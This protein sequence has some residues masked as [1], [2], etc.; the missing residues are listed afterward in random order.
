[1]SQTES[2]SAQFPISRRN[3]LGS[4]AVIGAGA[5]LSQCGEAA[6]AASFT[7]GVASGDPLPTAVILWTR[8]VPAGGAD[9]ALINWEISETEAFSSVLRSGYTIADGSLDFTVKVD[10]DGLSPG[11][12]YFYRFR[13]GRTSSP[14]GRTRTLPAGDPEH[15]TIAL[16]SCSNYAFGYFNAYADCARRDDIDV[17]VHVGDYIYEYGSG[18][19]GDA[20]M[21]AADR[22]LVPA[23]DLVTLADYRARYGL[24][25]S[26]PDLQEMHRRHPMIAVWDDHEV[27]NDAWMDGAENHHP[28]QGPWPVRRAA[29]VRASREWMPVRPALEADGARLYR[30]FEIGTLADLIVLD[31]RLYGREQQPRYGEVRDWEA[32]RREVL[33]S[34]RSILGAEQEAWVET[35]LGRAR[36]SGVRWR[37][38]AQQTLMGYMHPVDPQPLLEPGA[39][40]TPALKQ[41]IAQVAAI[42]RAELP[43]YPD[44]FGGGYRRARQR[45]LEAIVRNGGNAVVLSGDSHNAW[46]FN[47]RDEAG[48]VAAVEIGGTSVTSPGIESEL[49]VDPV[50]TAEAMASANPELTWCELASRGYAVVAVT[51]KAVSA[52]WLFVDTIASRQ[53]TTRVGNRLEVGYSDAPGTSSFVRA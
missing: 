25:R 10:A 53:F 36:T 44:S 33:E 2:P 35:Q 14:I 26:D 47:L 49:P 23:G 17:V 4:A 16:M 9:H 3:L 7:H 21:E 5:I 30:K 6:A 27:A 40:L 32:F 18:K 39:A 20:A 29:A 12:S 11:R 37:L 28:D 45:L 19:Y 52:Q 51:P 34:D 48:M 31:T 42:A 43:T 41:T 24:Y 13:C 46:A 22:R 50:R 38:L 1:M 8:A 15:F